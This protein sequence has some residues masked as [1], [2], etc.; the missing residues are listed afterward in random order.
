LTLAEA[1]VNSGGAAST[2]GAPAAAA[3]HDLTDAC[4]KSSAPVCVMQWG[5][6]MVFSAK[7]SKA[8]NV[9]VCAILKASF[10]ISAQRISSVHVNC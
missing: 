8:V 4:T 5:A 6:P 10:V 1:P 2:D 9:Q 3:A 7:Q